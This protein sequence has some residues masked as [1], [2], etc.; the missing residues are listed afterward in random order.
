MLFAVVIPVMLA[1]DCLCL[2]PFYLAENRA[3]DMLVMSNKAQE[4]LCDGYKSCS[5]HFELQTFK[6]QRNAN[7]FNP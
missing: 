7:Q 4:T 3:I 2:E 6:L 5:D 1:Y